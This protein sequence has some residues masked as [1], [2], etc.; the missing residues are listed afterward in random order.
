MMGPVEKQPVLAESCPPYI[1]FS[2]LLGAWSMAYHTK[3]YIRSQQQK[4]ISTTLESPQHFDGNLRR[5]SFLD[6]NL[7]LHG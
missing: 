6:N 2:C 7:P 1:S 4:K 3:M 5:Y